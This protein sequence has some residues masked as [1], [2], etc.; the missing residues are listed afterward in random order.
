MSENQGLNLEHLC[1]RIADEFQLLGCFMCGKKAEQ[2]IG[3][4]PPG[5]LKPF[6]SRLFK[7]KKP[8]YFNEVRFFKFKEDERK[9]VSYLALIPIEIQNI[10]YPFLGLIY[11]N[12][13]RLQELLRY[14]ILPM[15]LTFFLRQGLAEQ[16]AL[17]NQGKDSTLLVEALE[18]K[19]LYAQALEN[20]LKSLKGEIERVKQA[21]MSLDQK[22]LELSRLLDQ[23]QESYSE[24]ADAYNNMFSEFQELQQDYLTTCVDFEQKVDDLQSQNDQMSKVLEEKINQ[25]GNGSAEQAKLILQLRTQLKQAEQVAERNR[26]QFRDLKQTYGDIPPERVRELSETNIGLTAKLDQYRKRCFQLELSLKNLK[27]KTR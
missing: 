10:P 25:E 4:R 12:P 21:E 19:R 22:V 2:W 7:M 16:Q 13:D 6:L 27:D 15:Y 17:I 9:V 5:E 8:D 14:R 18:E 3:D 26:R 1:I 20:R 11:E 24:L 23:Q